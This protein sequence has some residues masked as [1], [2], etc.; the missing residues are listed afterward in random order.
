MCTCGPSASCLHADTLTST[1]ALMLTWRFQ[2][3]FADEHCRKMPTVCRLL[4]Q[5][6][7][8][9]GVISADKVRS[10]NAAGGWVPEPGLRMW[11]QP[12]H[13]SQGSTLEESSFI[14]SESKAAQ[15]FVMT[16]GDHDVEYVHVCAMHKRAG[17]PMHVDE[18]G[19]RVGPRLV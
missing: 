5:H 6:K 13:A 4:R 14:K 18:L 15:L 3:H 12:E 2:F 8:V 1:L 19:Q 17:A 7:Q 11:V 10:I 16:F 9:S